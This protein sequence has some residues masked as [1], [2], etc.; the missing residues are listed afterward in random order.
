MSPL[1]I[2]LKRNALWL[3]AAL[4]L[5]STS[6]FAAIHVTERDACGTYAAKAVYQNRTQTLARCGFNG[7]RSQAQCMR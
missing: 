7:A 4:L 6:S 1:Q 2:N 5:A 3:S